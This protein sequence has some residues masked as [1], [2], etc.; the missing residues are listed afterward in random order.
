M[1][2]GLSPVEVEERLPEI[3]QRTLA[4]NTLVQDVRYGLRMLAKSPGFTAVAVLTLALGIGANTAVFTFVNAVLL[5]PL[6]YPNSDQ[7]V[8]IAE[9]PPH[10]AD[11]VDVHPLNF[12]EWEE[13]A[14]SF[15]ALVLTQSIPVNII[16]PDGAEQ[17]SGMWI[18]AGL[19]KVFGVAP[20]LGRG[21]NEEEVAGVGEPPTASAHVVILSYA[22]WVERFASDR[23]IVGKA[24][25]LGGGNETVIGVMPAGFRVGMHEADVYLPMPLD[26][27]NPGSIG[28]HSFDCYG[29][30]RAG[31]DLASAQAEMAV[32][33]ERLG[34]QYP[35]D[36]GWGVAV[37]NLHDYITMD[38]RPVLLVLLGVVGFILLI[39]CSNLA[40][41]L[42]ARGV[43]R[44]G[45]LVIRAALGASGFRLIQQLL[46]ESLL[47]SLAGGIVGL[48][49]GNWAS[50]L[51]IALTQGAASIARIEEAHLDLHVLGFTLGLSLLTAVLCGFVPAWQASKSGLQP[52]LKEQG[53]SLSDTRGQQRLRSALAIGEIALAA[54]LLVG[55][56]L[57]L[58]TFSQLLNVKLGFEPQRVL[59]MQLL[60][61]GEAAQRSNKVEAILDRVQ[62]LPEVRA[63]GT[64]Q[65]LPLG[66]TSGTGFYF[67]GEPKPAPSEAFQTEASLVSRGYF[68]AMGIPVLRGRSFDE[69]DRIGRPRVC[70]INE[71]F[72]KK[73]FPGRDPLGRRLV[74]AWTDEA[75]TEIVGIVGDIRQNGLTT[76][77]RPTVF[78]AQAQVPA[79][80]LHLVVRTTSEPERLA[81]VIRH[82]IQQVDK[83]QPVTKVATMEYY[84]A[85]TLAKQLYGILLGAFAALALLLSA[86]GIYGLMAYAVSQRTHEIGIRI[87]SLRGAA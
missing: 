13:Q 33:A 70:L 23:N 35:M 15:E 45:E 8:F 78:M 21:F 32:L 63:V 62:A 24:V 4:L 6:P 1:L 58:R 46:A 36:E 22:Y 27:H 52:A 61:L 68:S 53:R 86:V 40:G 5:K 73:Y 48:V 51:L 41:L 34:R 85:G 74:V 65:Y 37:L 18:T 56:G 67:D 25:P 77:P 55:A 38:S 50:Q 83:N 43:A 47:L 9:R 69:R 87:G 71:S 42:L 39:A 10:R 66:P 19:S 72:A 81:A 2:K 7:V 20:M 16:G 17:I 75:P 44:R 31:V 49:I 82:E 3:T 84:L 59:T 57:L 28:S 79:Y 60:V 29:R 26:R 76:E 80:V 14:R 54:V 12:L 30:L 64:I 11:L